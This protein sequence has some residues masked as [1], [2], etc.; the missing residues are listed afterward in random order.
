MLVKIKSNDMERREGMTLKQHRFW[1]W[2]A[3]FC[4]MMLLITGYKHK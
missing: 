3:L 4:M 2:S 1:A